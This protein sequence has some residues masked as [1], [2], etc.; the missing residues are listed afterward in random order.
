MP[1][2]LSS[3]KNVLSKFSSKKITLHVNDIK[4]QHYKKIFYKLI[5]NNK[6]DEDEELSE[7]AMPRI[8]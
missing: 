8:T 1:G 6:R 5:L 7:S 2:L 4:L 3:K